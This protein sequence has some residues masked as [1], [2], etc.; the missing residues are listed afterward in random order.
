MDRQTKKKQ[1]RKT[2]SSRSLFS[3]NRKRIIEERK[4]LPIYSARERLISEIAAS[5]AVVIVGETG[6]GK[7]TQVCQYIYEAQLHM[8]PRGTERKGST[9]RRELAIAVTQPRRVAAR[10][11][12]ARVAQEMNSALGDLVGY[13]VRFESVFDPTR[14]RIKFLTDGMLLREL[15]LDPLLSTYSVVIL[16]EAHERTLATDLLFGLLK[17]LQQSQRRPDLKIV[18]MSATLDAELFA[19]YFGANVLYIQG[20]QYPIDIFYTLNPQPNYVDAAVITILQIHLEQSAGDILCFLTGREEIE[21][22]ARILEERSKLFPPNTP[23]LVVCPLYGAQTPE[24]QQRVFMSSDPQRYRK[25]VLA[26]NIAETSITVPYIKYVIDSGVVKARLPHVQSAQ[27]LA[28]SSASLTFSTSASSLVVVPISK[29]QAWQ[30]AG[31]CGRDPSVGQ[32]VVYRLYPEKEFLSLADSFPPEILRIKNLD[33]LV[34]TLLDLGFTNLFDFPFLQRPNPS[35]LKKSLETLYMLGALN[36][37]GSVSELGRQMAVFPLEPA[38]AKVLVMSKEFSCTEEILTIIAMLCVENVF[39]APHMS[40]QHSPTAEEILN[41][42]K[43]FD[44]PG[45]DH[46]VLLNVYNAYLENRCSNAWCR[47]HFLNAKALQKV[48]KVRKQLLEYW[49]ALGRRRRHRPEAS[50]PLEEGQ[51]TTSEWPVHSCGTDTTRVRKCFVTGFFLN[52]ATLLTSTVA[53]SAGHITGT[54]HSRSSPPPPPSRGV[55]QLLLQHHTAQ[56]HPSSVLFGHQPPQCVLFNELVTPRYLPLLRRYE[57]ERHKT[58]H[59]CGLLVAPLS[60]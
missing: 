53:S 32:G 56:I 43:M 50:C 23:P 38:Y 6:C 26:T 34:L 44:H 33:A 21:N 30:R 41:N 8:V 19:N 47:K 15:Q 27:T 28:G 37:D 12:A 13:S 9:H 4:K 57:R 46:L 24:Q 1:W 3:E 40:L 29:A 17:H 35:D 54:T 49:Q 20:R 60:L 42:R 39:A 25:V 36:R 59:S 16:D 52:A 18:V 45:G 7:T 55:Y 10:S 22:A 2:K 14:T 5:S 48:Q 51:S 58:S 31:R 11:V